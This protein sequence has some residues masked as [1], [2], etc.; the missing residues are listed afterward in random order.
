MTRRFTPFLAATSLL[1]LT[2]CGDSDV[3]SSWNQE[4]GGFLDR[5]NFGAAT[6]NNEQYHN[7][8][9][10]YAVNLNTRFRQEVQSTVTFAFNSA[11]LDADARA[12]L[13]VQANWIR[14]FPELRFKVY[15]HTDLVGSNAYNKRLGKRRANAV[16]A[17]LATR[18]IGPDRLEAVVSFG[19]TRPLI[20]TEMEE[21]QNRRTVT[22]VAGF[23]KR[24]PTV[25][26]GK[27]AQII[28]REYVDSAT[29]APPTAE[30]GID[31]IEG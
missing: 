16:V 21:R 17:Y 11:V 30:A 7:G 19:E 27:Y 4:A 18:G 2:A 29:E 24:H 9:R 28:Y 26:D 5:G 20:Y 14:Q 15:G 8:T 13:D 12:V 31:A 22:E 23:M 10:D 1:A 6:L 3:F 25:L